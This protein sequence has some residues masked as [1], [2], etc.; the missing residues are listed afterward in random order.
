VPSISMACRSS[1][2]ARRP[3]AIQHGLRSRLK[4]RLT[5]TADTL[6]DLRAEYDKG[7]ELFFILGA[8]NLAQVLPWHR[9]REHLRLSGA[10]PPARCRH[11]AD[12]WR[13]RIGARKKGATM[14]SYTH[15]PHPRTIERLEHRDKPVKTADV[16]R[17][18]ANVR[19]NAWR[20]SRSPTESAR[21][22][23]PMCS[24]P[25]H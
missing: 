18:E 12:G 13:C 17:A 14:S 2:P 5:Y 24:R 11:A 19:F 1:R 20:R 15:V 8:D 25:S 23:A 22:G 10:L 7:A 4:P 21:C 16:L 9:S 3:T 6:R